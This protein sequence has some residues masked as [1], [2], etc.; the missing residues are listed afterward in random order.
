MAIVRIINQVAH[1]TVPRSG[2]LDNVGI[3]ARDDTREAKWRFTEGG[4]V[5]EVEVTVWVDAPTANH[6]FSGPRVNRALRPPFPTLE[7]G[8]TTRVQEEHLKVERRTGDALL[9]RKYVP[10]ESLSNNCLF[11]LFVCGTPP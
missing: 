9:V 11:V 6:P 7:E 2:P 10:V 4:L 5:V 8:W 1:W 3:R